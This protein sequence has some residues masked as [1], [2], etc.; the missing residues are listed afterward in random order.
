MNY[1]KRIIDFYKSEALINPKILSTY[2]HDDIILE[3]NS[4]TGYIKMN[5]DDLLSLATE[6]S[7]SYI[8]SKVDI[9]HILK[10]GNFISV[11]YTHSIKT[12][13]NPREYILLANFIVI[14]EIKDEKL[15]RGYQIS[16]VV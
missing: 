15:Y 14:W 1:K 2:L 7:R 9:S 6:L 10:D 4:S 8:S 16:Q 13:E 11:R 3:W 5:R 12:I